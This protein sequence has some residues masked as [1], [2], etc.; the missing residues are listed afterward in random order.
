[1]IISTSKE[2]FIQAFCE[3]FEGTLVAPDFG[4][5]RMINFKQKQISKFIK[6][7]LPSI[8]DNEL[9]NK[10]FSSEIC[11]YLYKFFS[12]YYEKGNFIA[13][14]KCIAPDNDVLL[15]WRN[16]DQYY[17]KTDFVSQGGSRKKA[18]DFFIHKD[19]EG[20]LKRELDFFIKHEVLGLNEL[21]EPDRVKTQLTKAGVIKNIAEKIIAFLAQIENFQ[22]KLWLK[23]KFVLRTEYVITLDR[24][25]ASVKDEILD[26]LLN[27]EAQIN[28]WRELGILDGHL[29]REFL[30]SHPTLYVDTK[31]LPEELKLKLLASFEDLDEATQGIL[32]KSENFQALNLL[33]GKY[34]EK[35]QCIYIDPPYNTGKDDFMFKDKYRHSTWL[36]MMD[37]RLRLAKELMKAD[38]IFLSNID[39]NEVD[40]YTLLLNKIFG[41]NQTDKMIWKKASEGRWGKMK[42]VNTFR[43]D[44]EYIIVAYKGLQKMEKLREK[45]QFKH[46]YKNYDNDPRGPYKVGSISN[47]EEASNPK[48]PYYYTVKSPSGKEF[49]RQWNFDKETFEKLDKDGRIYWGKYGDSVPGMKIFLEEERLVTP[50]SVLIEKGTNTEAKD[51]FVNILGENFKVLVN[52]LNPKPSKLIM[53]LLQISSGKTSLVF[54]FFAGSGTT[55]HAVLRLNKEDEGKRRYI[56]V[57]IGD[58]F[59]AIMV[60]RIKK[61]MFS[62]SWKDGKPFKN[63]EVFDGHSH[64]FKYQYLEQYEDALDNIEFKR[65]GLFEKGRPEYILSYMLDF[66]TA[67]SP[68]RLDPTRLTDPFNYKLRIRKRDGGF[69]DVAV[70]LI[71]TFNYLMGIHVKKLLSLQDGER[72]YRVV[73]GLREKNRR[74]AVI[75]RPTL[76]MTEDDYKR[77]KEFLKESL[78]EL[79]ECEEIYTNADSVLDRAKS[80]DP[81]FMEKMWEE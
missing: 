74:V 28:E 39:D 11:D 51:E 70:D 20:F 1:M 12:Q 63:N 49:T 22:K 2:H 35:V 6:E 37:D 17:V 57:E 61:I 42:N 55:A 5:Y 31:Y 53:T 69:E 66:E 36:S 64:I 68:C 3:L 54:D 46:K 40:N 33:L 26:N 29:T 81:L 14:P 50:Y 7:E 8:I 13:R 79:A 60:S 43:K 24:I 47:K 76:G 62:G 44:H 41:D 78:P 34:R 32:I 52:R 75:W 16:Q 80:L 56:L 38:A 77:E 10:E 72:P 21:L 65:E 18:V 19:I 48:H 71:E 4:I 9:G 30:L 15:Y 45:P 58:W 67:G 73:L 27:N 59:E 23:R 25:P